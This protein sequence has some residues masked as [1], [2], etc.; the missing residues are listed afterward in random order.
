[1]PSKAVKA[2]AQIYLTRASLPVFE[3]YHVRRY[4]EEGWQRWDDDGG[5][6]HPQSERQWAAA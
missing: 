6:L 1:L 2:H 4:I 3:N 5:A